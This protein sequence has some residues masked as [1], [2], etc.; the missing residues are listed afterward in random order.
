MADRA[1]H[2]G[3][4]TLADLDAMAR[5]CRNWGRWGPDDEIG[6]LNY[7]TPERR[8][9]AMRSVES[10]RI[11]PLAIPLD[12]TGPQTG[13]LGRFNPQH[14]M[15][16]SGADSA[17]NEVRGV[18]MDYA[19][20]VLILP[21][22]CGTQWDA[23]SHVFYQGKMWNGYDMTLV[24]AAGAQRNSIVPASTQLVGRG[25]LLDVAAHRRVDALGPAELITSA[26][27]DA[28][29]DAE[30]VV[31]EEGDLVVIRTG[32]L[33]VKRQVAWEG[34]AGGAGPGVGLET[35]QWCFERKVAAVASDNVA[36]EIRP[37]ETVET[38]LPW[39]QVVIANMG[40]SVG[41]MFDLSEL[42]AVCAALGRYT[43]LLIA[44]GLP[45]TYAVGTPVNPLAVF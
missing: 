14:F 3:T 27:L 34:F 42:S 35:A 39:H 38:H 11:V 2:V 1:P 13:R 37:S 30:G 4:K 33:E 17:A 6:T 20:D 12:D 10:G 45:V 26:E 7:V 15:L 9:R 8:A 32:W 41:E 18:K 44:V 36:V 40:L 5:R 25:V 22:Q 28:V 29:A 24:N 23:L 21:L 31:I 16:A 19:D 43:F